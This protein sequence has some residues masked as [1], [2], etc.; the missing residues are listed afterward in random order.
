MSSPTFVFKVLAII[1]TAAATIT[2][3]TIIMSPGYQSLLVVAPFAVASSS[4]FADAI[5]ICK[6]HVSTI[7]MVDILNTIAFTNY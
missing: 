3:N 4:S 6:T 1:V 5:Y 7:L 2:F